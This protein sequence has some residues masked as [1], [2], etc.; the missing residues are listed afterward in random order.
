MLRIDGI[1]EPSY[2]LHITMASAMKNYLPG[3]LTIA[4]MAQYFVIFCKID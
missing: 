1:I 3:V 4:A 2:S